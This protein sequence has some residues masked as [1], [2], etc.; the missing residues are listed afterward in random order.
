MSSKAKFSLFRRKTEAQR[1][2]HLHLL[3]AHNPSSQ[4]TLLFLHANHVPQVPLGTLC[5]W[6]RRCHGG[7]HLLNEETEARCPRSCGP[8]PHRPSQDYKPLLVD[9]LLG[10][11]EINT[12]AHSPCLFLLKIK[13]SS[14]M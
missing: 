4:N 5:L 10:F 1:G 11:T 7:S 12:R 3:T 8:R 6:R 14:W 9:R 13:T 2:S